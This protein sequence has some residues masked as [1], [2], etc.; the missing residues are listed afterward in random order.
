[1]WIELDL[2]FSYLYQQDAS[3]EEKYR[4]LHEWISLNT[5]FMPKITEFREA[6][7]DP[8]LIPFDLFIGD[9]RFFIRQHLIRQGSK[10]IVSMFHINEFLHQYNY[11]KMF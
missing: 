9:F 11:F 6:T 3:D 7:M 10:K 1:M 2:L 5:P 8:P 4:A